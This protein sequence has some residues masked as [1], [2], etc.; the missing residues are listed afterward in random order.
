M[1]PMG[2]AS[3]RAALLYLHSTPDRQRAPADAIAQRALNDLGGA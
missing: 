3:S 1:E 2:H